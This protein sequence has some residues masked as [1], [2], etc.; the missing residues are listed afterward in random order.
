MA[1]TSAQKA[2]VNALLN[3]PQDPRP[4]LLIFGDRE[5]GRQLPKR[6]L[7]HQIFL[8]ETCRLSKGLSLIFTEDGGCA[9]DKIINEVFGLT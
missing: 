5:M 9:K 7:S 2:F 8:P 4:G 6:S 1:V 3:T